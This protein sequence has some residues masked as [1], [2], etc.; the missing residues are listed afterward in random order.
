MNIVD[1]A[2][3]ALGSA[4]LLGLLVLVAI[5]GAKRRHEGRRL[6]SAVDSKWQKLKVEI[7]A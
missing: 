6:V 2:S 4:I 1:T 5:D 3:A 7:P